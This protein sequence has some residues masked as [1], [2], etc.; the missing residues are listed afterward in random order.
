MLLHTSTVGRGPSCKRE[1]NRPRVRSGQP[2]SAHFNG[3]NVAAQ[4]AQSSRFS[5]TQVLRTGTESARGHSR[6]ALIVG[7]QGE[8]TICEI[9]AMQR[10]PTFAVSSSQDHPRHDGMAGLPSEAEMGV[11]RPGAQTEAVVA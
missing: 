10:K 4:R 3:Q 7:Y 6:R 11:I 9:D 5:A 1:R 2:D 8:A